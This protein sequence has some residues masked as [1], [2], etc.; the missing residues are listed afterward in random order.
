MPHPDNPCVHCLCGEVILCMKRIGTYS[1]NTTGQ[2]RL[3]HSVNTNKKELLIKLKA[4][5]Q[6]HDPAINHF[7]QKDMDGLFFK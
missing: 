1:R 3:R 7:I 4:K 2:G 5:D 6:L